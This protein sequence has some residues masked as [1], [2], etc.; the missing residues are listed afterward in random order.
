MLKILLS[1][2]EVMELNTQGK[3]ESANEGILIVKSYE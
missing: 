3:V 1:D 2:L